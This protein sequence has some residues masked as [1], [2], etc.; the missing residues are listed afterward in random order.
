MRR[1]I[2]FAAAALLAFATVGPA[3]PRQVGATVSAAGALD[4]TFGDGGSVVTDLGQWDSTL[5]MSLGTGAVVLAVTGNGVVILRYRPDGSL[6]PGFSGDGIVEVGSEAFVGDISFDAAGAVLLMVDAWGP[7]SA[8]PLLERYLPAGTLDTTFGSGGTVQLEG[9]WLRDMS[10]QPD[11]SIVLVGDTSERDVVLLR[12]DP[13]GTLDP[14][15]GDDGV[16]EVD[17]GTINDF[18]WKAAV[19]PNGRIV[20]IATRNVCDEEFF[21]RTKA[22]LMRFDGDGSLDPTFG[23]GGQVRWRWRDLD[24]IDVVVDARG[25]ALVLMGSYGS[26]G[27]ASS[28]FRLIRFRPSGGVAK[29]FGHEGRLQAGPMEATSLALQADGRILVAGHYCATGGPFDFAIARLLNSGALDTDFGT[30]GWS[31]P[32]LGPFDSRATAIGL[33]PD[34]GIVLA[35][36]AYP[37]DMGGEATDVAVARYLPA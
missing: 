5:A 21:C 10:L 16:A 35:G 7:Q 25:R 24:A 3:A 4:T 17:L 19:A 32:R 8:T 31:A 30:G 11:G 34:G 15:F 9:F 22:V 29:G 26:W 13:N 23:D 12:L 14:T 2:G 27:C 18:G 36:T 1:T 33:Q 6:D 37:E 28:G 20:V